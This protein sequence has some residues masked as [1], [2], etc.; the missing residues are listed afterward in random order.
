MKSLF[1]E[2]DYF[3]NEQKL[4]ELWLD[5]ETLFVLDTNVLLNLY[6]Y[7]DAT[8][9]A[10]YKSLDKV[11]DRLWV[12]HQV[13][14]EFHKNRP[15]I[16]YK[17]KKY[18]DLIVGHLDAFIEAHKCN[19]K[20]L[21]TFDTNFGKMYPELRGLFTNFKES[22]Q[23]KINEL[24]LK[25]EEEAKPIKEK[26]KELKKQTISLTGTDH[27]YQKLL[28]F[29]P[30]EKVG[31]PFDQ[32]VLDKIYEEG[33]V[34]YANEIPPGYKDAHK[35]EEFLNR[36]ILYKSKFGDL[37]LYKQIL[38]FSSDIKIKN[39][40]FISEDSKKDWKESVPHEN[41]KYYGV[42]R[43]IREEAFK[44]AGILNFLVFNTEEFIKHSKVK[45]DTSLVADL[46]A[47]HEKYINISNLLDTSV[48]G[49]NQ[50]NIH[51][52]DE[53]IIT[54]ESNITVLSTQ[55]EQIKFEEKHLKL[56]L[57]SIQEEIIGF[58]RRIVEDFEKLEDFELH[59]QHLMLRDLNI[60]KEMLLE[61]LDNLESQLR[62]SSKKRFFLRRELD[63][64]LTIKHNELKDLDS[65]I[66]EDINENLRFIKHRS[67]SEMRESAPENLSTRRARSASEMRENA[68]ESLS[69]RRARSA[70]EM[71]ENAPEDLNTRRKQSSIASRRKNINDENSD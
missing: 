19:D 58:E 40:I 2:F 67:A 32:E 5:T 29:Y 17:S 21:I 25:L 1:F 33:A 4:A 53:E 50:G 16:I 68:P 51:G 64:L 54:L 62:Q 27:I 3:L 70:S 18:F 20:E 11:N 60:S 23:T 12:P 47:V 46:N 31:L 6:S 24:I 56:Q 49:N 44:E 48:I 14:L 45:L 71:R 34:R 22:S 30:D 8:R 41:N 7:Q 57:N 9:K 26:A 15:E 55:I 61:N 43:E 63:K 42:R 52:L 66:I 38:K 65:N 59:Q 69:T 39:V 35:S 37:I 36:G 10:I 28:E 13:M